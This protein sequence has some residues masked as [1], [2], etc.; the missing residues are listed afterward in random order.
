M[1]TVVSLVGALSVFGLVAASSAPAQTCV[2]DCGDIGM[3]R[4]ND[5]ILG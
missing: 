4:I 1:R 5:L 2:G 3:V